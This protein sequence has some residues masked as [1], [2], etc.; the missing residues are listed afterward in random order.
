MTQ[1]FVKQ[2]IEGCTAGLPAQIK[3]Y[4]Q[5]NQPVKIID[6]TLSEVIGAVINNTLCGG[7]GGGGW[8]A[9]DGGEQKNSS[10]VQSKFCAD[11]GKKVSFFAEH[12]PHCGCSGFKAK[13]KQKGTKVTNP[14]DGR[15]G[16]SA[17]SHFQYK[18]ELKEYRLSLVEPLNDRH[19]CRE[20]RF[21]YWTLDKNSEHLD[22]YA[23]AQLN[24]KKSNHINFQPY[25]VDFYLSRPVM[26][27][28]G[29]LTVHEDR[30]EFD[31]DF[32]DLDNTIPVEIPAEFACK[33][34]KS[35]VESKKFG[36]ERGEWVRN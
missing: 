14:R 10:H 9:C 13:S 35:V 18:D 2:V 8:D 22:L 23:Q 32:F 5:F 24:S 4:T 25:G 16:I 6:D 36:K 11:C 31:F 28:T 33:D 1:L 12:C 29:V 15:W 20:F 19:D 3:Y 21:T 34:S 30:T 26:K 27:F 7:S 17:K